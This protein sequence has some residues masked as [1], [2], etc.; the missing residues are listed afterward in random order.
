MDN[1]ELNKSRAEFE[2]EIRKLNPDISLERWP[3]GHY[4]HNAVDGHWRGWQLALARA[5]SAAPAGQTER[6]KQ[7]EVVVRAACDD[8][9]KI[10]DALG[11]EEGGAIDADIMVLHIHHLR[12]A[13]P[14]G[15]APAGQQAEPVAIY[16]TRPKVPNGMAWEDVDQRAYDTASSIPNFE[17][18]IVYAVPLPTKE[19]AGEVDAKDAALWRFIVRD[20]KSL[21]GRFTLVRCDG[22]KLT[23]L[24][25]GEYESAVKAAIAA[26]P[27]DTTDTKEKA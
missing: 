19:G 15:A 5:G 12:T 22:D 16:Q 1:K 10:H 11:L 13:W 4:K 14:E 20:G 3:A 21:N 2:A 6:E 17:A 7:L 8:L 24:H 27:K 25:G 26:Q 9:T 18:R 23:E